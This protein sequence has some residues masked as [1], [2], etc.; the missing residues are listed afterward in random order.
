MGISNISETMK[1]FWL[2]KDG[3]CAINSVFTLLYFSQVLITT[4][5]ATVVA[6]LNCGQHQVTF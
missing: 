2:E 6:A 4:N 3:I 5:A 1:Y